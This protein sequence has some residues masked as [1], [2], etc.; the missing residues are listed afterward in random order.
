M[1]IEK[2]T[3]EQFCTVKQITHE[4]IKVVYPKYYPEGAVK[5]FLSHH[6]NDNILSDIQKEC[7][8]IFK[9]NNDYV[10]TASIKGNEIC[11]LFVLPELQGLGYGSK[12]MDFAEETIFKISET[13][14]LDASFSAQEMYLKRGYKEIGYYKI[15][16]DNGDF[17]CYSK[18]KLSKPE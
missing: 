10:G 7:V 17:L 9:V 11:R 14:I 4:T 16:T 3:I 1:I 13:I 18:M 2:A 15:C 6:S 8:Y 5:F 12:I